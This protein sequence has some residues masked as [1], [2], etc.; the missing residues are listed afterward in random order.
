MS[1]RHRRGEPVD[2]R[3]PRQWDREQREVA[4]RLDRAEAGWLVMYGVGGR[5]FYAIAAGWVPEPLVVQAGTAEELCALMRETEEAK[6][7]TP[8]GVRPVPEFHRQKESHRRTETHGQ[9]EFHRHGQGDL[10]IAGTPD[11]LRTVC[12]DIP[13]DPATVGEARR[14]TR[15]TL[16]G[17]GLA[18]EFADDAV[19]VVGEL[20]ANATLYGEEPIRLSLW[21]MPQ[22]V[23]VRVT[24]HGSERPRKLSLGEDAS[25]G[26]GLAI[27]EALADRWGVV[28]VPGG[29]GKTVWA[30]WGISRSQSDASRAIDCMDPVPS[31][32]GHEGASITS[33]YVP[34][35]GFM[36]SSYA[37]EGAFVRSSSVIEAAFMASAQFRTGDLLS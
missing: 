31:S 11:G 18:P 13:R 29:I 24:D 5:R 1:G 22:G 3:G 32:R 6:P 15:E 30:A 37:P 36:S 16:T 14:M 2:Q 21:G 4:A 19:L 17:W 9:A 20:V 28:P 10:M 23:C 12:W 25:H 34:E 8:S 27:V 26:R 7:A 35:K 33:P